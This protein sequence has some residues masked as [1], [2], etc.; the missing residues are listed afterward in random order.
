MFNHP[1][2]NRNPGVKAKVDI[3]LTEG[4]FLDALKKFEGKKL[5]DA[6]RKE[7]EA[8]KAREVTEEK[9]FAPLM[10]LVKSLI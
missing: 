6:L 4:G 5:V 7:V 9:I 10:K 8:M 3:V 1:V 2:G